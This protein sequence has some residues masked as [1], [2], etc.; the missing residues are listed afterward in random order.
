MIKIS[1]EDNTHNRMRKL[2]KKYQLD[3]YNEIIEILMKSE[4][5]LSELE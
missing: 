2:G 3:T 1:I 5:I 4:K